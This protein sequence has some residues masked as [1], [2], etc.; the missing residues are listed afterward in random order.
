MKGLLKASGAG[1]STKNPFSPY[2]MLYY[3][4][5]ASKGP[6]SPRTQGLGKILL[7]EASAHGD[8]FHI[9]LS[10]SLL[11]ARSPLTS[12][13]GKLFNSSL[14]S[15]RSFLCMAMRIAGKIIGRTNTEYLSPNPEWSTNKNIDKC[16]YQKPQN[17]YCVSRR[18]RCKVRLE[19][20]RCS[21]LRAFKTN[22]QTT[23]R[24]S[25]LFCSSQSVLSILLF[26][27]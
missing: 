1:N 20:F 21:E 14:T 26:A 27:M 18:L 6:M 24:F 11:S 9:F 13:A 10:M 8:S 16:P 12:S 22:A 4:D 7:L 2:V 23:N 5:A 25:F 19:A 3:D 15:L 17:K